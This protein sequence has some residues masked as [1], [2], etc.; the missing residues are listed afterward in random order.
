MTVEY[1]IYS[2]KGEAPYERCQHLTG[3]AKDG[4]RVVNVH[5]RLAAFD[6]K[7]WTTEYLLEREAP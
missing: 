2:A 6:G 5:Q 3:L 1:T 4:W 7:P